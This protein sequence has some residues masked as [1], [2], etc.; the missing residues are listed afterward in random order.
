LL[1][2]T[3]KVRGSIIVSQFDWEYYLLSACSLA[4]VVGV[5]LFIVLFAT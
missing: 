5:F 2:R 4:L 3:A 1:S